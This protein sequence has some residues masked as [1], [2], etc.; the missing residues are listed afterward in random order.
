MKATKKD[1][2]IFNEIKSKYNL[3]EG[4]LARLFKSKVSKALKN[5]KTIAQALKDGDK[6]LGDLKKNIDK[7]EKKGYKIPPALKKYI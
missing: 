3:K 5:D 6:A 2:A 7:L 4:L 1:K